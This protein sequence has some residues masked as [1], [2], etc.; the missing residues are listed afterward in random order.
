MNFQSADV[1]N[2]TQLLRDVICCVC[3]N[4][5]FSL[6]SVFPYIV[7]CD[8]SLSQA[9]VVVLAFE[10]PLLLGAFDALIFLLEDR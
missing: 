6:S 2:I 4:A 1:C 9:F 10:K 3:C 7:A 8:V 5:F